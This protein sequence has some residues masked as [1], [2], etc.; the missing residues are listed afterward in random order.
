MI[1]KS[2]CFS[3]SLSR[4]ATPPPPRRRIA[5][6]VD[7]D[8][9]V[10]RGG[11]RRWLPSVTVPSLDLSTASAPRGALAE[12]G[13][14]AS[15]QASREQQEPR[16]TLP[17]HAERLLKAMCSV[18]R[19]HSVSILALCPSSRLRGASGR[20]R[21]GSR[22]LLNAQAWEPLPSQNK[23][24]ILNCLR[25]M[26]AASY[27]CDSATWTCQRLEIAVEG[28]EREE[29]FVEAPRPRSCSHGSY[30]FLEVRDRERK[31]RR[32]RERALLVDEAR[33]L[34][35]NR[36]CAAQARAR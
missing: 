29:R 16:R 22:P 8:H 12:A 21:W 35:A 7:G 36:T 33:R 19:P 26:P 15:L 18:W 9:Q 32:F 13:A 28:A 3:A 1:R 10:F 34:R 30:A 6:V 2:P 23:R 11:P 24:M 27:Q 17:V 31:M 4:R 14:S 20:G 25:P 5:V